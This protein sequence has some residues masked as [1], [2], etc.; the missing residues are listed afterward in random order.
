MSAPMSVFGRNLP[1]SL[2]LIVVFKKLRCSNPVAAALLLMLLMQSGPIKAQAPAESAAQASGRIIV[3]IKPA[4]AAETEAQFSVTAPG[5]P[6]QVHPG[7]SGSAR[8]DAFLRRQSAQQISPL[9]PQ[10]IRL[11]KRHGWSD[12]EV[13]NHLRQRFASRARRVAHAKALPEVSRTYILDF[14]SLTP[15][16][17]TRTLLRLKADPD[18]E[19]A[20]PTHTFSTNQLP[21]DPFLAT[22]GSWGQPYQDLWGL[23]AINAPTAWDTAQGDG[24]VVAVIDTG[25]DYTHPDIAANIWTNANEVDGN[26][27][28]D[29]GNGFVDDVRGWNFIFN[30]NDPSDH[31]GH[32]TH[33]AGTIAALGN[34]GMG[35]IGVA[36]HSQIMPLK[37]LDDNGFGFDFTLAPAIIYAA[38]NGADVINA[39]W[40]TGSSSQSIEEAIQFATGLGTVFVT[41][42]GNSSQDATSFFPANSPEAITVASH[43][44][45]G[46]FSFFSNFGSRIDVT[47]PGE[48]I[49]SLQAAG[50][51]AGPPVI[52]GYIRMTG[53]SMAAPHVS[54]VAALIL[55]G[56]PGYSADLVRQI[57]RVSNTSVPFDSRFGAGKLNAAAA[58]SIVNPLQP[59][60]TGLQFG[61]TPID[62][63][64]ILGSAQGTGF[65]SY[66]LEYG[67]GAQPGFFTPFFSSATPASG[68]LGQFDPS[69]LSDGTYT[70]RLTAFNTNGNAFVD[71]TQFT[72]VLCNITSPFP[73][74]PPRSATAYKPGLLLP[75][76]GTAIIGG[77]QNFV[78]E[79]APNGTNAWQTAGITLSGNGASPVVNG[80]IATWDTSAAAQAGFTQAGFYQIRLSVNGAISE[81]AFTSIY[82]EP[83]LLSTAWPVF[84]DLSPYAINSGVVPA[85]NADGTL[86]LVMESP[87]QGVGPAASWAF[88]LDGTFQKTPLN[89]FGSDHQPAAGNLDGQPG[90]EAIMPDSNVIR[91]FQPNN[92]FD[93]FTP[94][95]DVDLTRV[96][97]LL[98]DLNND[99][100]LESI[101]VG[102]DFNNQSAY[103]FAW[104]PDGQQAPGFPIQVQDQSSLNG[105]FNHTRVIAGDFDGDGAKDI[106]VQEGLTSTTYALRL[107]NHDGTAKPFN[108][109]VLTGVPFAM[110]AA[111][112]DHN[113][114]LETILVNYNGFSP[115]QATLHV[116]QPDGSERSGWPVDISASNGNGSSLASISVGD[117]RRDG[118]EE[119]VVAREP[120]IYLFNSDGTL[121]SSAWPLPPHFPGYGPAV[122]GDIDG[123]GF[124]EIVTTLNDFSSPDGA[125]L[126]AIR[127]DGTVAK[128]WLMPGSNGI[129][130]VIGSP[131]PVLGDFNQDGT[132]DIALAYMLS[133]NSGDNPGLLTLL[134]THA[135]FNPT[136]TDWPMNFQNPRNNPVLLRTSASNLAVTL[137]TGSNPSILGDN[138]VFT[139]TLMPATG[140]GSIQFL[141]GG[142]P[143]SA[144]IPL[145][146]GSASFSTADLGLGTHSIAA[147]YTGDNK[148]S[149][150]VS[151]ALA[152]TVNKP[153]TS[154]S[155]ALAAGTNPSL[156]GDAL[157]FM[158]NVTPNSATGTVVFFDGSSAISGDVILVNGTASF[159]TSQ[160]SFGTHS[161]TVQYSGDAGFNGSTSLALSQTVNNPKANSV[162]SLSLSAGVNPSVFGNS[163]TFMANVIPASAS[164]TIV[165]FDGSSPISGNLT[166]IGGTVSLTIPALGAGTHSITAHY[167][168]DA[169][170]NPSTSAAWIQMVNKANTA[171]TLVQAEDI[172]GLKL[173]APG[174]FMATVT[175][176]NAT[177]SVVFFDGTTPISAAIPLN[178]GA[179]VFTTSTLA[180]G[181]HMISA[182]Y[183]GNANFNGS[184]SNS[185]KVK[186]K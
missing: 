127:S 174:T 65:A 119:I 33:V 11:K 100:Q 133:A 50:T 68:V 108:A 44:P 134:D 34:N 184:L 165:F 89:L 162:T 135:P 13:A 59:K 116:F 143:I 5:Q 180:T 12:A 99:F 25:V 177:G 15:K 112:L 85:L 106:L 62:P 70:I 136:Q 64:T 150:S 93:L 122:I 10:I 148:L 182:Q 26:F 96:P 124:P 75:I 157:T 60:I 7:H 130:F 166:L 131:A 73:G 20:E 140:N 23:F 123:D 183:G 58:V 126:L 94:G 6:M 97:L 35:V 158:A 79:W 176:A 43:D 40:S 160:L 110:A 145:N 29:D 115:T 80:Q 82:L 105:W 186:V 138:L 19:F 61:A 30:N 42:A 117:F 118:H 41:A 101:T 18:V 103:V 128:S 125:K 9:Y 36:W 132:I 98:E 149:S 175:P 172:D 171:I 51:F 151:P 67:A 71:T 178:S 156:V 66:L 57:I 114:K 141:D 129:G 152:Q 146:S 102:S 56:N 78:V 92:S 45:F 24:I 91:I 14:G 28:D 168:G 167:S 104:K 8:L 144:S 1:S 39:S 63:I 27:I 181:T 52:P 87:N 38:S 37:G 3:K 173:G 163:L 22:S 16:E 121:F 142:A 169:N 32:G 88:N 107:F 74:A 137:S 154:V 153:N 55:S 86:R 170:V 179:A 76:T 159:T 139:A 113:G 111:D 155:V 48:D 31:N 2:T 17:Q 81:Q 53:T 84:F 120:G 109:P 54:G 77:F 90:D 161:I 164:G 147:R 4:L 46:N 21:N 185:V 95:L 83:D 69:N 47:A 49:L 72:L